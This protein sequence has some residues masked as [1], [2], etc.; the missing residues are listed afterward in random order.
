[1][2]NKNVILVSVIL[3]LIAAAGGFYGGMKY[4]GNKNPQ[5]NFLANG[6]NFQGMRQGGGNGSGNRTGAGFVN[7]EILKKDDKSITVKLPDGGSKIVY[8]S[9]KA[10]ISKSASGTPSDLEI[11]KQVMVNG[12]ANSDGSITANLIQIR[13]Q[14][15]PTNNK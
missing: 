15:M 13:P 9:D 8:L 3:I 12:T 14:N 5:K 6:A 4:A 1:M 7:G 2:S 11:G 10:E